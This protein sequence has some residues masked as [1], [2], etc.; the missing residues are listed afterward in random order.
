MAR[1]CVYLCPSVAPSLPICVLGGGPAGSSAA[2]L[3]AEWGHNVRLITRPAGEPRLAESLP[4]SCYK[5]FEAIGISAAIA[6][7]SFIR[8]RG[9]TV[10]WGSGEPRHETFADHARGWQV[11]AH[12]LEE[13]LLAQAALAGA[14]IERRS[15]ADSDLD[16]AAAA[17]I[18]DCTGRSGVL[19]RATGVRVYDDGPRTVALVA[20]WRREPAW[21][22]PDDSHT[23][24]E[25][26]AAGWA[27]SVPTAAGRRHI[28]VMVD[29]QR[30]G[31]ARGVPAR[32]IYL[33]EIAKTRVFRDQTR[34]ASFTAGPWGW[35][36]STYHA[37]AYAG[38]GWLLAGDAGSFID[39]L[40]SAGV[41]KA[42]ASGWLAAIVAHT[43]VARPEMRAAA[44]AFFSARE[45]EVEAEF[46][47]A[48]R[49]FLAG[50]A[51]GHQ[52]AFWND[53]AE[54]PGPEGNATPL[55]EGADVRA[56]FEALRQAPQPSLRRG[57]V[58]VEPRPAIHGHEI[59][60]EPRIITAD[61]PAGI[62]Y[63]RNVDLLALLELAP[64][65][66]H[67]PDLYEAYGQRV[68]Q[69]ALPDFL[70]ALA[71]VLARGWLVAE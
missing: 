7:A 13:V 23:L 35:D 48:S 57:P 27:W 4:P 51:A 55:E 49:R 2:R 71:S 52:H 60:M 1:I 39:P 16:P 54:L 8:S 6:R 45:A 21:P 10:W 32:D 41:K 5:L 62:R 38:D 50:A 22:V 69:A 31:L 12:Q 17:F 67:V 37:T 29:P 11:D 44:G 33:G 25:S 58:L 40:S 61:R 14:S 36:A 53:R 56:A 59:V 19:A 68:A 26:Y 18:L 65:F 70:R 28:A 47:K 3:L 43:T 20:E 66:S 42:L 63:V 64:T 46:A 24:V 9:N 34:G 30:S 15:I